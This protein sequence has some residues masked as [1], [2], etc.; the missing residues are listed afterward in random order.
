MILHYE[1]GSSAQ[2]ADA[3]TLQQRNQL[4]LQTRHRDWLAGQLP[5]RPENVL[6]ARR[7]R[8]G[9]KR[10]LMIE[11]RVPHEKLGSGYPRA[12]TIL[13][14]L[15][16]RA[17]VTFFPMAGDKE[18][19]PAVRRVVPA[20]VE[21]MIEGARPSLA[22]FLK[23]R[24]GQFDAILI[25]RPHNMEAFLEAG[26]ADPGLTVGAQ[27]IYDAEAIFATREV[28]RLACQ[29]KPVPPAEADRLLREEIALAGHASQVIAVSPADQRLFQSHGFRTVRV[30]SH[31]FELDPTPTCFEDR[32]D[33]LFVGAMHEDDS[34]NADSLRWFAREVLPSLRRKLREDLRLKVVGFNRVASIQALDGDALDL[35]GPVE[36]LRPHFA[37]ARFLVAPTRYAAGIPHKLGQAA[38]LGVPIVA[39]DLLADQ[40]GWVSGRDLLAATDAEAFAD[41][42]ARLFTDRSLWDRLRR[43]AMERCREAWSHEAF[44]AAVSQILESVGEQDEA[45]SRAPAE[46]RQALA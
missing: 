46:Q 1:F 7:R 9:A 24:R 26:G 10:I 5:N 40:V 13:K 39:T 4:T 34:P 3:I 22:S 15:A 37:A 12:G 21:V 8:A 45:P 41:A 32:P 17:E 38:A 14:E 33:I 6:P 44:Q 42:C 27:I 18:Y 23:E 30:L 11:D 35:V 36:D 43:S 28:Q 25:C 29:G 2:A 19:W 31:T 20:N 16:A